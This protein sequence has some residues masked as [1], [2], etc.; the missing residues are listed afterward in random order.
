MTPVGGVVVAV[1]LFAVAVP[2]VF[3]AHDVGL[4]ER[5]TAG[6]RRDGGGGRG[7]LVEEKEKKE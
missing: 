4:L 1:A 7:R 2:A 3:G 6:G 5:R